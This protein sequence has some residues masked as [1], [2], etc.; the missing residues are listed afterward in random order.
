MV[1]SHESNTTSTLTFTILYII[2]MV[3][4]LLISGL[5]RQW[6]HVE[7]EHQNPYR[8]VYSI[9]KFAKS[10]KHPLRRSAFTHCDNYIPSRLDFAKE[11]FGGPFTT[12]QVENVKTFLRIL[13][14]LFAVGPAFALEVPGSVFIFRFFGLHLLHPYHHHKNYKEYCTSKFAW[15][16]MMGSGITMYLV[17]TVILFPSYI[18]I[19]FFHLHK[20]IPKLFV[21]LGIGIS[22]CLLGVVSLLITDVVGHALNRTSSSNQSLCVFQTILSN[23]RSLIY[24][25]LNMHWTVLIPPNL[26]LGIG[27]LLVVATTLEFISAQSPQSSGVARGVHVGSYAPSQY[28]SAPLKIYIL[29]GP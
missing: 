10:H 29:S 27:P 4:L 26:L 20:K 19:F 17:S 2:L 1:C 8:T 13:L 12:E 14:I 23:Q 22:L 16:F 11:R 24:P 18:W 9:I 3:A 25:S 5:K 15:K 21:R 28:I 7:P 6:F